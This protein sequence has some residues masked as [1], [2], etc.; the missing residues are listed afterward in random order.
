MRAVRVAVVPATLSP[1]PFDLAGSLFLARAGELAFSV[2]EL[3]APHSY[4]VALMPGFIK[5][6]CLCYT[7][8]MDQRDGF[9]TLAEA[10]ALAGYASAG[11][12]RLAVASG[13]LRAVKAGKRV[14]LTRRE[15]LDAYLATLHPG[16]YR[17]GQQ[18][19]GQ[20]AGGEA[21]E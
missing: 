2:W 12:L 6:L 17:R 21:G 18:R 3:F 8:R 5:R 10:A 13:K 4:I 7:G 1:S 11:G 15:W 19:K 14:N 20:D 9:I 16:N